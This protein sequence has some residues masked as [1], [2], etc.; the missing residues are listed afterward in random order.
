MI[1]T[2]K[3]LSEKISAG[4]IE[5]EMITDMMEDEGLNVILT[6]CTGTL[7]RMIDEKMFDLKKSNKEEVG[8]LSRVMGGNVNIEQAHRHLQTSVFLYSFLRLLQSSG[9]IE[10]NSNK[11]DMKV[12]ANEIIKK[13]FKKK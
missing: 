6:E 1:E 13:N 4:G 3:E 12:I 5:N 8:V 7:L 11:K 2:I 9:V 10:M